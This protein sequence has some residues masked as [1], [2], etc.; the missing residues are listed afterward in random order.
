MPS[1]TTFL[2]SLGNQGALANVRSVLDERERDDWLI[3]GLALRVEEW[4]RATAT[5]TDPSR[6]A[7]GAA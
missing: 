2:R 4:D 3:A 7:A 6:R 1:V 5:A